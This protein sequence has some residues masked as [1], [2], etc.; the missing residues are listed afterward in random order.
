MSRGNSKET[1][2][3]SNIEAS[4]SLPVVIFQSTGSLACSQSGRQASSETLS[5][6]RAK[7]QRHIWESLDEIAG[8]PY[9]ETSQLKGCDHPSTPFSIS[10]LVSHKQSWISRYLRETLVQY[11][12]D[13]NKDKR[14]LTEQTQCWETEQCKN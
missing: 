2:I 6:L 8:S 3:K 4:N 7:T 9:S 14:S 5:Y 10:I 13:Q 1:E 11:N 12:R